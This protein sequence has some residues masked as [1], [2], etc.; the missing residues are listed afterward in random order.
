MTDDVIIRYCSEL[1]DEI[2]VV[3]MK[4]GVCGF[5]GSLIVSLKSMKQAT[6][7]PDRVFLILSNPISYHGYVINQPYSRLFYLPFLIGVFWM[8]PSP[9]FGGM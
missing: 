9:F 3:F 1:C 6:K 5:V 2:F 8:P 7:L 4:N